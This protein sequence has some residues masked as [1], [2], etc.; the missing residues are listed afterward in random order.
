MYNIGVKNIVTSIK[1]L[2]KSTPENNFEPYILKTQGILLVALLLCAIEIGYVTDRYLAIRAMDLLAS[3]LPS[4]LTEET[5]QKR[6]ENALPQLT[7]NPL[8][9]KAA[10]LKAQDMAS[11]GYFSHDTPDGKTPWYWLD[12]VGYTYKYAGENL[13]VNFSES[14][15]VTLAWMNSPSHRANIVKGDY[16]EIGIATAKG[17]YKG[18]ETIFVVQ[19]FGTPNKSFNLSDVLP[20]IP[21]TKA[22]PKAVTSKTLKPEQIKTPVKNDKK[23]QNTV[24]GEETIETH[25]ISTPK[26]LNKSFGGVA[27]LV[28]IVLIANA[29][30]GRKI[31]FMPVL[32]SA[33]LIALIALLIYI[34]EQILPAH[35]LTDTSLFIPLV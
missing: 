10:E 34:N 13:A 27:V 1:N 6:L 25:S 26:K 18:K 22:S 7:T 23:I 16:T 17:V 4:V 28:V 31:P 32:R 19:F 33:L 35:L 2:F 5:N 20:K 8:L 24:L 29:L 15:D 11:R 30:T 9:V 12:Q 3:V 21:S 14:T